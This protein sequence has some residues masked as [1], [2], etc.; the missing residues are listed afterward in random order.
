MAKNGR[1]A[2]SL[3]TELSSWACA[4]YHFLAPMSGHSKTGILSGKIATSEGILHG[5]SQCGGKRQFSRLSASQV[6][7]IVPPG[8]LY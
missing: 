2:T 4:V 6:T 8:S 7:G 1:R 5:G 3:G